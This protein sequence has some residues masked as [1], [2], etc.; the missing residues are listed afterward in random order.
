MDDLQSLLE[1]GQKQEEQKQKEPEPKEQR[2]P[3]ALNV[4][5]RHSKIARLW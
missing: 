2:R 1:A 5:F 3:S 4:I